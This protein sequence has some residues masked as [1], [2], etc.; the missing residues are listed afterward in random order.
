MKPTEHLKAVI[1]DWAG[2][3]IDYGC[4]APMHAF[5]QTFEEAGVPISTREA[6]IPMGL[7]KWDHIQ[8]ILQMA[9]VKDAWTTKHSSEPDQLDVDRLY[10]RFEFILL[11]SLKKY[12]DPIP[13][14]LETVSLLRERGIAIGSSTGYTAKMMEIIVSEARSK[15]YSPDFIV[16]ADEVKAGRPYPYMIFRNL[17]ALGIYPPRSVMKVGDT[18]SDIHEGRNAG[19]WTVG[20]LKG[21]S[22]LGLSQEEVAS[23]PLD[24]LNE[25]IAE[26]RR[27]FAEAGADFIIDSIADLPS[28]IEALERREQEGEPE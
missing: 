10:A 3:V 26:T 2:T 13:G 5:R 9:R 18:V 15:G 24:E 20:V 21:G 27:A 17:E 19:V 25:K 14:A 16:A 12:T 28:V 6:R 7:L 23:L 11:E 4:F 22:E 8:A 1:L